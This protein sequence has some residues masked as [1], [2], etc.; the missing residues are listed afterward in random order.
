MR[1]YELQIDYYESRIVFKEYSYFKY[2][3]P[4]KI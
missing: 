3:M 2:L 1:V 4:N